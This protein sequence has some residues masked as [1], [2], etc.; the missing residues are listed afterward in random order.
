MSGQWGNSL[1]SDRTQRK[2][3]FQTNDLIS[4]VVLWHSGR[5]FRG[6]KCWPIARKVIKTYS[7]QAV[8]SARLRNNK[9]NKL[10]SLKL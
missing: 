6:K 10:K 1:W 9:I 5:N 4:L 8:G 2:D 3:L 7:N